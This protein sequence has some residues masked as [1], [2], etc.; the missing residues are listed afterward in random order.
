MNAF[1][2]LC[3]ARFHS[4]TDCAYSAILLLLTSLS[5]HF[6]WMRVE[7]WSVALPDVPL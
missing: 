1:P 2:A 7:F 6:D 5:S 4:S 3:V